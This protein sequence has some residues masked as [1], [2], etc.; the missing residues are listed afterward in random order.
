MMARS[1]T[2]KSGKSNEL[3]E[4]MLGGGECKSILDNVFPMVTAECAPEDPMPVQTG[5]ELASGFAT[6]TTALNDEFKDS[7]SNRALA[8]RK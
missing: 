5:L 2:M 7:A 6:E 3:D 4:W 1:E 8:F